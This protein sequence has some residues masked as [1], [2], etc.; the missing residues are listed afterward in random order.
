MNYGFSEIQIDD[1]EK[2]TANL[3]DPRVKTKWVSDK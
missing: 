2:R 1:V 3:E